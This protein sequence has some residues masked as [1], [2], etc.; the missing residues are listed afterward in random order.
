MSKKFRRVLFWSIFCL[1]VLA[2]LILVIFS[3]GYRFDWEKSEIVKTS[4]LFLKISPRDSQIYIDQELLKKKPSLLTGGIYLQG[5]LPKEYQIEVKKDGYFSWRKS[6][7]L[8]SNLVEYFTN[9][10]LLPIDPYQEEIY[11]KLN[12]TTTEELVEAF[13][14]KKQEQLILEIKERIGNNNYVVLKIFDLRS[15]EFQEIFRKKIIGKENPALVKNL[16]VNNREDRILFSY[17]DN[18]TKQKIFY[19]W[20]KSNPK[21]VLDFSNLLKTYVKRQVSKIIF[22]PYE[23][24]KFIFSTASR[25][26][27]LDLDKKTVDYFPAVNPLD[28]FVNRHH[29]FWI[30]QGGAIFSYNFI[31]NETTTLGILEGEENLMVEKFQSSFNSQHLILHLKDGRMFL[32]RAGQPIKL[33]SENNRL[34]E[35]SPDS[36]KLIYDD[37]GKLKILFLEILFQDIIKKAGEEIEINFVQGDFQKVF[38]WPDSFHFLVQGEKIYFSEIDDRGGINFFSYN[39]GSGQYYFLDHFLYQLDNQIIKRI[40]FRVKI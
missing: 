29:L 34:V 3:F 13:P 40:D 23:E 16:V 26:G 27:L 21:E 22:H 9:I 19:L 6:L 31:L 24:N 35:F 33:L 10:L 7:E 32:I 38:W 36:K 4:A 14:L 18:N 25:L 1:F 8:Q 15:K 5:F 30:D 11:R 12:S 37:K 17:F 20:E 2:S 28:F 39:F